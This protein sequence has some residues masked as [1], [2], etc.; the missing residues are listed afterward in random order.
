M[1]RVDVLGIGFDRVDLERAV[2][3]VLERLRRGE[4]TT[5][6]TAN[7]EFVM[8]ARREAD[9]RA[10][11]ARADLVIPDG[12]GVLLASRVL[13]DPLPGR[14]PG[15]FLVDALAARAAPLG[16]SFFLLGAAPGVAERAGARLRERHPELR[17]VGTYH[18]SSG[19]DADSDTVARVGAAAPH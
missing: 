13:G 17:I 9:L 4:R 16:V 14:A 5:V 8:L 18:G 2:G 1:S 11:A 6:I 7:P 12:T 19:P 15:R 10:I 3:V